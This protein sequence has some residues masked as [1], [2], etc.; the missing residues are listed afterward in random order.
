MITIRKVIEENYSTINDFVKN[1]KFNLRFKFANNDMLEISVM[2]SDPITK[3]LSV[4]HTFMFSKL[5]YLEKYEDED[6]FK[7]HISAY[8]DKF[9][10]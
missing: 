5:E 9:F 1:E 10:K 6:L 4:V 2:Y 7:S 3:E 8:P